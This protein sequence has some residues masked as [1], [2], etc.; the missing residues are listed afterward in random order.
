MAMFTE[1]E[2]ADQ[3]RRIELQTAAYFEAGKDEHEAD[4]YQAF[5]AGQIH[6]LGSVGALLP[7][8]VESLS[9]ALALA[10]AQCDQKK[11]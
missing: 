10:R 2:R 7:E 6:A 5:V 9:D 8:Q 1:Q 11:A 3:V 4:E